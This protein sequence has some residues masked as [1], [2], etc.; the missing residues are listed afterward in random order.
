[1]RPPFAARAPTR[2]IEAIGALLM[3]IAIKNASDLLVERLNRRAALNRR[4]PED[5]ARAILE[6]A[7]ADAPPVTGPAAV[8]AEIRSL[9]LRT[10]SE[11]VE[12]IREFRDR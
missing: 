8:A 10:P 7:L 12:I 5:E 3:N 2:Y 4:T 1:M 9:G 6:Q 11:S